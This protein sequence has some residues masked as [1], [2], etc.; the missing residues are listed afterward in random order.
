MFK[1][2]TVKKRVAW[3][4]K[5]NTEIYGNGSMVTPYKCECGEYEYDPKTHWYKLKYK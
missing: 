4:E 1:Y 2:K 5:C 3:C